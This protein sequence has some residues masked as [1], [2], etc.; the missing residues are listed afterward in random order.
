M[1]AGCI[2]PGQVPIVNREYSPSPEEAAFARRVIEENEKAEAAGRASFAI[3]GKMVD[4]P[5]VERARRL[6]ARLAAIEA[7]EARKVAGAG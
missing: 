6:L 5:V 1:G 7:R 3:D 4:V 2:H